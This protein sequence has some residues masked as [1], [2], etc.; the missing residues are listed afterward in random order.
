[1]V[2]SIGLRDDWRNGGWRIMIM[3]WLHA[4]LLFGWMMRRLRE[5]ILLKKY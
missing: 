2:F 3:P 1:M 5:R 4:H